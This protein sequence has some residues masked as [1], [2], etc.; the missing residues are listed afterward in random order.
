VYRWWSTTRSAQQHTAA[1]ILFATGTLV[2]TAPKLVMRGAMFQE[3]ANSIPL[4][5]G[6]VSIILLLI[7]VGLGL[8]TR[9]QDRL[10][11]EGMKKEIEQLRRENERAKVVHEMA[12]TLSATLNYQRVL[13]AILDLS[14]MGLAE[15]GGQDAA[16]TGLVLL[17]KEENNFER[18]KVHAGRNIPRSDEDRVVSGQ[19]GLIAKAIY[20][21]EPVIRGEVSNDP[22]LKQFVCLQAARSV[23][24]APLRA[25]FDTYGV[26]IFASQ[27]A[28]DFT[29]E[30]AELLTTFC[31]QAIVSLKNAQLYQDLQ[32]E[33]RKILDKES[34]ARHKLARELHDGPTQTISALTM[35]LNFVRM[36]FEKGQPSKKVEDEVAKIEELAQKATHEIR[37]MLFTLR[38]V[39]LE[40]QGLVPALEQYADRLCQDEKLNVEVD[41]EDYDGQLSKEAE[42]AVFAVIEEAVGNAKKHAH[43]DRVVVRLQAD[44]RMFTAEIQDDGIGFD[45]EAAQQ[46]REVGHLGLLNMEERA[47]LVRGRCSIQSKS[48]AG[49]LV[50]VNIPLRQ[51]SN[52]E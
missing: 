15:V 16:L 5:I 30:H 18:L 47:R 37:T 35:R 36:M 6:M 4:L 51:W 40:T 33:Q 42:A 27:K 21:A 24:C 22:I 34:E 1:P 43:A 39:V 45:M 32:A 29:D 14:A 11:I 17:F 48:G 20:T 19:S 44:D 2:A 23:I 49:T 7:G 10:R 46:R 3:L 8:L 9:S 26:V 41:A 52:S 50:R 31:N 13:K 38:P 25:G 28:N 12:S